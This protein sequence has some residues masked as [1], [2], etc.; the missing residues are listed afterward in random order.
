ME[1]MDEVRIWSDARTATEIRE[2]MCK[3]LTGNEDGLLAYYSF[4]NSSGTTLQDFSGNGYDG[5]LTNMDN[6]DWVASSA[7]NTWL[8]TSSS[9][10]S[11][12]SNWSRGSIPPTAQ[13]WDNLG[14]FSYSAGTDLNM[15]HSEMGANNLVVTSGAS[16]TLNGYLGL[17]GNLIL[18]NDLDLNGNTIDLGENSLLIESAG[19]LY[20]STWFN[21]GFEQSLE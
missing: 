10:W 16:G 6:S 8:N 12:A 1:K 13:P 11:T 4:D 15:N 3:N 17:T 9:N 7:F 2:N 21:Q 5:T 20:G 19:R 18:E 14:I